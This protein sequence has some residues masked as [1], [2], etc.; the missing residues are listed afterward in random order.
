M[1]PPTISLLTDFGLRDPFVGVMKGVIAVR[2]PEARVID[3]THA[4][5][6]QAISEAAF[7]LSRSY[8][9]LPP[10]TVHVVVVDPGV[11]TERR[12]IVVE[13]REHLFVAPD[14]GVLDGVITTESRCFEVE[15]HALGLPI[16]SQ[17]FHGRDVFAPVAAE[18]ASGRLT[19]EGLGSQIEIRP[20]Q[21]REAATESTDTRVGRVA[22]VDHFGNII[23]DIE[24]TRVDGWTEARVEV[25]GVAAP[26]RRTYADVSSGAFVGLVNA[27]GTVELALRGGDAAA[28]L[29]TE[30]GT[31]F[32]VRR[33]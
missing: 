3:L 11:G 14:N 18:L 22:V 24:G 4:I 27:F 26:L 17:T 5:R 31:A 20:A 10:G 16:P 13:E 2:C 12:A 15:P 9:W 21:R 1:S 28:A 6:P 33:G 30:P 23:S 19:L 25:A 8:L 29:G 7:W 32:V